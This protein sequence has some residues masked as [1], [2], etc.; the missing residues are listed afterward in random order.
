MGITGITNGCFDP[1][2]IGHIYNLAICKSK[3]DKLIIFL[4][5][6]ESIRNLKG[7]NRPYQLVHE[8]KFVLHSI[9][10]VNDVIVFDTEKELE[11]LML[12]Y[13]PDILFKGIDYHNKKITGSQYAKKVEFIPLY[14]DWSS[15]KL[16]DMFMRLKKL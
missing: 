4:N 13:R 15:T 12:K 9:R 16:I 14:S 10:Y 5:S 6:D 3:V 2:H 7:K 1:I 8:R 11:I